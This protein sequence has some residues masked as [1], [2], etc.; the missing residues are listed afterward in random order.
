MSGRNKLYI[1]NFR[2]FLILMIVLMYS[3]MAYDYNADY[4]YMNYILSSAPIINS[5][6]SLFAT[7]LVDYIDLFVMGSVFFLSGLFAFKSFDSWGAR[8]YLQNRFAISIIP[9]FF[10][11][12]VVMPFAYYLSFINSGDHASFT[13]YWAYFYFQNYWNPGPAWFFW[14]LFLFNIIFAAIRYFC[15]PIL[16]KLIKN[17]EKMSEINVTLAGMLIL[18]IVFVVSFVVCPSRAVDSWVNIIGPLW[19]PFNRVFYYFMLF[20][21]GSIIGSSDKLYKHLIDGKGN[22][23]SKYYYWLFLSVSCFVILKLLEHSGYILY[24]ASY[25][26]ILQNTISS[27]LQGFASVTALM[28]FLA[29]SKKFLDFEIKCFTYFGKI[30]FVIYIL[31]FPIMTLAQYCLQSYEM[32]VDLKFLAVFAITILISS[33]LA[34]LF[35]RLNSFKVIF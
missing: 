20:F 14:V 33:I 17:A 2:G 31:F 25:N 28:G 32:P 34:Y 10:A 27:T 19:L 26:N 8:G 3:G 18:I 16:H 4:N 23:V 5:S 24:N 13:D 35:D 30:S 9:F 6:K 29:G 1:E 21:I 7:Y 22:F 12:T 11:V 15:N